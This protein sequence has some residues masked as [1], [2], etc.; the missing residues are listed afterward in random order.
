MRILRNYVL[1]EISYFFFACLF[2]LT[3]LLICGNV[4]TK[5]ADLV[6]N[7]GVD[8]F[9]LLELLFFSAPFLFTFTIPVSVLIAVLLA[10]GKLSA[11]LEIT[12]MK[13]SGVSLWR[14]ARPVLVGALALSVFALYI[15]DRISS[16]SHFRV[17]QITAEIGMKTPVSI[18]EEGVFIKHFKDIVLFI[19]RIEGEELHGVRI[20][21]PQMS[22]PTRTIAAEKGTLVT[23]PE[24]NMVQLKLM[25]GTTDEPDADDPSKFYK[26]HFD[27]YYLPL[28]LSNYKFREP[29]AKKPKEMSIAELLSE[30]KRIKSEE[31][32]TAHDLAAEVHRKIATSLSVFVFA[33]IG[34]PLAIRTRRGEKAI[35]FAVALAL[36]TLYWSL[37]LGAVA[38]AKTGTVDPALCLHAPNALFLAAGIFLTRRVFRY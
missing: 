37:L 25:N 1:G 35:G 9:L 17:R 4:L 8:A 22:G 21:Q 33:L 16:E 31:N 18:L 3:F 20:Y 26:L 2:V 13:A 36:T 27:N 23:L 11:D 12:A 28:D 14:V 32:F 7:W 19:H 15:N 24:K 6:I 5:M 34:I 30:Y 38:L 10:F 29:L